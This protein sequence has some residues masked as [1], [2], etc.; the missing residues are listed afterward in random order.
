MKRPKR[1]R[2]WEGLKVKL[3]REV[4][5]SLYNIPAGTICTV[6]RNWGGLRL[7]APKCPQCGV[8]IFIT[9]IPEGDVVIVGERE[10]KP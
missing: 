10:D 9:H 5:N 8:S 4:Q 6:L 2:D 7:A 3:L 1:K